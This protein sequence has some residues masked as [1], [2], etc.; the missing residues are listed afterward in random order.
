MAS[1]RYR[2]RAATASG[3]MRSGILQGATVDDVIGQIRRQGL[4]PLEAVETAGSPR[5]L[6]T[7]RAGSPQ[8]L[9]NALGELGV[10]LQAGLTLDRALAVC[11][12]NILD[13][14]VR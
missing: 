8:A 5:T 2:Y 11:V 12:D 6:G 9:I 1:Y 3:A 7:R 4:L 14:A 13:A 10:L